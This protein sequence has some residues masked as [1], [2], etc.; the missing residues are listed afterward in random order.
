MYMTLSHAVQSPH[1]NDLNYWNFPVFLTAFPEAGNSAGHTHCYG[2][3]RAEPNPESLPSVPTTED[4]TKA[5]PHDHTPVAST[6]GFPSVVAR[7]RFGRQIKSTK[8]PD[9]VYCVNYV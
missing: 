1:S 4:N 5:V 2:T 8:D 7:S 3:L 9:F 6:E